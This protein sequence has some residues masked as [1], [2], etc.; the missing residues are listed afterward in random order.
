MFITTLC[1]I[2]GFYPRYVYAIVMGRNIT[3]EVKEQI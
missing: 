3:S 1:E 2:T